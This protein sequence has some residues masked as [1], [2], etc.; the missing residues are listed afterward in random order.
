MPA[1]SE[2]LK[3][4]VLQQALAAVE[5]EPKKLSRYLEFF[6]DE[7]AVSDC[8][9]IAEVID[10]AARPD[11]NDPVKLALHHALARWDYSTE[12][13]WTSDTEPKHP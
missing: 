11:L 12:A 5:R 9:D 2:D 10:R 4:K 8:I 13:G 1:A 6:G 3:I 7:L